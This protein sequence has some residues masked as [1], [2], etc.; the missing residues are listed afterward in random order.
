MRASNSPVAVIGNTYSVMADCPLLPIAA[1][2]Y[3]LNTA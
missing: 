3:R 1:L 2:A